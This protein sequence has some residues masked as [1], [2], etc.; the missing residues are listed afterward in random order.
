VAQPPLP[1]HEFFPLQPLS[2][3]LQPPLPLQEFCPWQACLSDFALSVCSETPGLPVETAALDVAAN[4][5][6][7]SPAIAAPA[8][9]A[10]FVMLPFCS[11]FLLAFAAA[12]YRRESIKL[13]A[14]IQLSGR[15][16]NGKQNVLATDAESTDKPGTARSGTKIFKFGSRKIE[17]IL[18]FFSIAQTELRIQF[19][20]M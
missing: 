18:S 6:L 14:T 2:P 1:L 16:R 11:W 13:F 10:F 9:I 15:A 17:L 20:A 12:E 3:V 4:E 8:T 19:V 5:P 7:I